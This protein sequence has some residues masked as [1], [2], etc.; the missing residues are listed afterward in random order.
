MS[1]PITDGERQLM[2]HVSMWGSDGY[3]I[4]KVQR[5]WIVDT[6]FGVNGPPTVYKTK[7]EAAAAFERFLDV[8]R[9]ALGAEA[10]AR[11]AAE[12]IAREL[13]IYTYADGRP[14][15]GRP[16]KPEADAPIEVKIAYLR[17]R[18]AYVDRAQDLINQ[19]FVKAFGVSP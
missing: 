1:R 15:E 18:A 7:R 5:K 16:E 17:E 19:G 13:P 10:Q 4:R 12:Q 9:E 8:L 3:P 11:T 6:M 14:V 2:T